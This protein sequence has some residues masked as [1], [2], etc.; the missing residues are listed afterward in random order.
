[1]CL[2]TCIVWLTLAEG[3]QV[4]WAGLMY[5]LSSHAP[6]ERYVSDK[7][8]RY[9]NVRRAPCPLRTVLVCKSQMH[10]S[11]TAHLL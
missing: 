10:M 4:Q 8:H 11:Q 6:N 1:M 5:L 3:A 9:L 7:E 2:D